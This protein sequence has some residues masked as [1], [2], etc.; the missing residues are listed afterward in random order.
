ML[1]IFLVAAAA[2]L[3]FVVV[4]TATDVLHPIRSSATPTTS[5]LK[6]ENAG[7]RQENYALRQAIIEEGIH[8]R[9]DRTLIADLRLK[10]SR[11]EA[12]FQ[13]AVS[14]EVARE[15]DRMALQSAETEFRLAEIKSDL[16]QLE[17]LAEESEMQ[18]RR[19]FARSILKNRQHRQALKTIASLQQQIVPVTV[20]AQ[21]IHATGEMLPTSQTVTVAPFSRPRTVGRQRMAP[22]RQADS[23][24]W[25]VLTPFWQ[26]A[27]MRP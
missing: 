24:T 13:A 21:T 1:R 26:D 11:M 18:S 19:Q 12:S 27:P 17:V 2:A 25:D 7:L 5:Q 23:H 16:L 4:L 15:R 10:L 14:A 3:S 9:S 6:A 22:A 20:G 8:S